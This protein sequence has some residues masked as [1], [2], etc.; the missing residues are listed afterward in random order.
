MRLTIAFWPRRDFSLDN[1]RSG[2]ADL[3][4]QRFQ[5]SS[6]VDDGNDEH[7]VILDAIDEPVAVDEAFADR[8]VI[9]LWHDASGIREV[10]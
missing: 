2:I 3:I 9:K 8:L 1:M 4:E 10:L 6:T 7:V 5:E